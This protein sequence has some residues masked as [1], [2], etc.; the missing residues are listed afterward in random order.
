MK[1]LLLTGLLATATLVSFAAT[2]TFD[3]TYANLSSASLD[4]TGTKATGVVSVAMRLDNPSMAG[5][6]ITGIR[7]YINTVKNISNTS[8][9]L[10]SELGDMSAD[11]FVPDIMQIDVTPTQSTLDGVSLG[12]LE[13]T[14]DTPYELTSEP[15]YIGYSL[16][17]DRIGGEG[18]EYPVIYTHSHNDNGFFMNSSYMS[19]P[20][21][22][23][24]AGLGTAAIVVTVEREAGDAY[25]GIASV[26]DTYAVENEA[27]DA[28]VTVYNLGNTPAENISYTYSFDDLSE[29][30]EGSLTFPSPLSPNFFATTAIAVPMEGLE[31]Q[32]THTV[33]FKITEVNGLPNPAPFSETSFDVTTVAF[34]P[35]HRPLVE[36]YT[37]LWCGYC[38]RGYI[39]MEY[40]NEI[41]GDEQV[42]VC[43]HDSDLMAV[44]KEF[45]GNVSGLPGAT[46]DRGA[47]MDPYYGSNYTDLGITADLEL[48]MR[49][50][51]LASIDVTANI[52][53]DVVNVSSS[54]LFNMDIDES[55]Y[56]IGYVLT[57]N[58]LT[59]PEW[60]QGNNF[61][62][63]NSFKGTPLEQAAEWPSP[64]YGL[65]Y[66]DVVVD[67]NGDKGVENSLPLEVKAMEPYTHTFSYNIKDNPLI[68]NPGYLVANAYLVNKETGRVMNANKFRLTEYDSVT[69]V[70]V[71]T[72]EKAR[73]Y[74]LH[75]QEV[76]NPAKGQLV[77]KKQ[78]NKTEKI[79]VR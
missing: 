17:V 45:P 32:G 3:F 55:P 50:P 42:S 10:S 11:K 40:I 62:K 58:G 13:A 23:N 2:E 47:G 64:V 41:Y 46:I 7:G 34:I 39:A 18:S 51:A 68:Q 16:T 27:F 44:T 28:Y 4:H 30:H 36:E 15:F 9:W 57:C 5:M 22:T 48:A 61:S 54:V 74:N 12:V 25:M 56:L 72:D 29:I 33:H 26:G 37:A 69:E 19:L 52:E 63:S 76:M 66:N 6:K 35:V 67:A 79:I 75:G 71:N 73:Y 1:K 60:A 49:E 21:W 53:D 70:T 78:G 59:D 20:R 24:Y 8:V 14:F 38:P 77:I 31:G 65:I 43:Y